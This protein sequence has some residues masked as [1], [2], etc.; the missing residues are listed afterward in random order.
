MLNKD[1][2]ETYVCIPKHKK[3]SKY[4]IMTSKGLLMQE[5]PNLLKDLAESENLLL[6]SWSFC[7]LP[8]NDSI[9]SKIIKAD[10]HAKIS[11]VH[12]LELDCIEKTNRRRVVRKIALKSM[13]VDTTVLAGWMEGVS[14][15]GHKFQQLVQNHFLKGTGLEMCHL[16]EI[17]IANTSIK[18]SELARIMPKVYTTGIDKMRDMYFASYEYINNEDFSHIFELNGLRWDKQTIQKVLVD[19]ARFHRHFMINLSSITHDPEL[20]SVIKCSTDNLASS[21]PLWRAMLDI[22]AAEYPNIFTASR[23]EMI[24]LYL[25]NLPGICKG[26]EKHSLTLVHNDFYPGM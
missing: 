8:S 17:Y 13:V 15:N 12:A 4:N 18:D 6:S 1:I 10:E 21:V 11:G 5:L 3:E 26:L 14:H 23:Y 24:K 22:N 19:L 16:K 20:G 2:S 7:D 9:Q 25:D